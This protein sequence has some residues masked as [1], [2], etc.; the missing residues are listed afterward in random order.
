MHV[1]GD[2]SLLPYWVARLAE[3]AGDWI[4]LVTLLVL[5]WNDTIDAALTAWTLAIWI[6]PRLIVWGVFEAWTSRLPNVS[7][8]MLVALRALAVV[9]FL[10]VVAAGLLPD[11]EA[12]LGAAGVL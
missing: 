12:I 1:L 5:A 9:G 6:A 11:N 4:V 8:P 3:R 10:I 7:W 2:R